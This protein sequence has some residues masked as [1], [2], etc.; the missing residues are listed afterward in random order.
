MST[1]EMFAVTD[2]EGMRCDLRCLNRVR[3]KN[4]LT[5]YTLRDLAKFQARAVEDLRNHG[6]VRFPEPTKGYKECE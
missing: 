4:R 5:P 1:T 2:K 6:R 3:A